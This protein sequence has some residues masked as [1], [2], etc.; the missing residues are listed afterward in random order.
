MPSYNPIEYLDRIFAIVIRTDNSRLALIRLLHPVVQPTEVSA[1][2]DRDVIITMHKQ[3]K[4]L[5]R[6]V[7]Q[8]RRCA[9]LFESE[10]Q[11]IFPVVMVSI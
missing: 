10:L 11:Q 6:V 4:A 5:L 7:K 2:S 8:V 9:T 1:R 3:S